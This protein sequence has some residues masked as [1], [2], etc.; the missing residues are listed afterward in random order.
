MSTTKVI[1]PDAHIVVVGEERLRRCSG[2][3][4]DCSLAN[5]D[6]KRGACSPA[7]DIVMG[8]SSMLEALHAVWSL[9]R[10]HET[11]AEIVFGCTTTSRKAF[12]WTC[13][14]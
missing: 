6:E 4:Q 11:F 13:E 7:P 10:S 14:R 8:T 12:R 1:L 9:A 2:L 3:G 5:T